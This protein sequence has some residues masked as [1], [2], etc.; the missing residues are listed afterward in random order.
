MQRS[1]ADSYRIVSIR[2]PVG[3]VIVLCPSKMAEFAEQK[4]DTVP[5]RTYI[6]ALH[7]NANL[8]LIFD[9]FI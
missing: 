1:N 8:K 3:L 4:M 7:I 9:Q 5:V 2:D 6:K